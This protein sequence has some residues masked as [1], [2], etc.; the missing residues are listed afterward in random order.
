MGVG[1]ESY[2]V[3]ELQKIEIDLDRSLKHIRAR[4]VCIHAL[5]AMFTLQS[6]PHW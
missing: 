5:D 6:R 2:T 4:K 1:L 3:E